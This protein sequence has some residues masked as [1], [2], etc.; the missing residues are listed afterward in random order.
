MRRLAAAVK[1]AEHFHIISGQRVTL[2][3]IADRLGV[4]RETARTR[5]RREKLLPSAVTWEGLARD[6]RKRSARKA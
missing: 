4:E 5:L 1:Q 3:Q 2:Q 6:G